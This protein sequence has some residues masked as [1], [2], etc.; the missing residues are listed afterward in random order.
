M[1]GGEIVP[2]A[3]T[4]AEAARAAVSEDESVT[5]QL[6]RMAEDTPQMQAAARDFAAKTAI[7]QAL[8]KRMWQKA[9]QMFRLG[10]EYFANDFAADMSE[11][12]SDIPDENLTEP[13]PNIAVPAMHAL[14][15]SL[16]EPELK[17]MYLNLIATATDNRVADHAHPS[18]VEVIR[19]LTGEEARL[20]N[21]IL[22]NHD[23]LP[24]AR[25]NINMTTGGYRTIAQH[26]I[27]VRDLASGTPTSDPSIPVW[28]DNWIRLGLV[29]VD[30][31]QHLIAPGKYDWVEQ[32]P[33]Y[34]AARQQAS[35]WNSGQP[36]DSEEPTYVPDFSKGMLSVTHFGK[37]FAKAVGARQAGT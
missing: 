35:S 13:K 14:G 28:V 3:T 34:E 31:M 4:V 18:F 6:A 23:V 9:A 17:A 10:E 7:K 22:A 36:D 21:S 1:S 37:R 20:L 29:S 30:Y 8:L 32:R 19:Q 5:Q 24:I 11:R 27:D 12:L 25:I 2:L 15:Y 16:D 26:V 33:E